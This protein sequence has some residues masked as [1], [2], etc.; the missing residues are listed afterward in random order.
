MKA[1]GSLK[2]E[3]SFYLEDLFGYVQDLRKSY[4]SLPKDEA[5]TKLKFLDSFEIKMRAGLKLISEKEEYF[6]IIETIRNPRE[7]LLKANKERYLAAI[8]KDKGKFDLGLLKELEAKLRKIPLIH[9]TKNKEL[10]LKN[11][12][13][14]AA[15]LWK[16][17]IKT[18]A[19]AMDIALG[20]HFHYVFFTHGLALENFSQDFVSIDNKAI[21]ESLVSSIDVYKIV[22]VKN[23]LDGKGIVPTNKWFVALED[24]AKQ[25]FSGADFFELKA[26]YIL[27][28][29]D[30]N[31]SAYDEF[32]RQHFYS[33][34]VL[35]APL[36]EY[37][38]L[39]E[40]KI[41]GDVLAEQ[42]IG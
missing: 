18:C 40:I 27:A 39:G 30:G 32:A 17:R 37:P 31:I 11:G 25:L 19:N 8:I 14:T 22:L 9:A 23:N 36:G 10:L 3:I 1:L 6:Q 12:I 35:N 33:N 4:N 16:N 34:E 5:E 29:F 7:D 26:A 15:N 20:L 21:N 13:L 38:F 2:Q 42:I 41:F 24:Y 28:Y